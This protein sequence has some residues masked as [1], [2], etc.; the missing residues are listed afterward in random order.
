MKNNV[1][2]NCYNINTTNI[3]PGIPRSMLSCVPTS[4]DSI[5]LSPTP[6]C[7]YAVEENFKKISSADK[8]NWL[9]SCKEEAQ[10][11]RFLESNTD[12]S[13]YLLIFYE[14]KKLVPKFLFDN[15]ILNEPG[16]LLARIGYTRYFKVN[17]HK[18]LI[19]DDSVYMLPY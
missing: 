16:R 19:T 10:Y 8:N 5:T 15:A 14:D 1:K 11:Y 7:R 4:L 2:I 6:V 18:I 12:N 3:S 9:V 17:N 13:I